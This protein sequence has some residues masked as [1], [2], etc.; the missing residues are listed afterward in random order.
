VYGWLVVMH[1]H[2]F[3]FRLSL[4]HRLSCVVRP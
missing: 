4:T 2:L 1:T 3:Y